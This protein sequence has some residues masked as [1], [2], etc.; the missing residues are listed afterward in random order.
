MPSR[1]QVPGSSSIYTKCTELVLGIQ[2]ASNSAVFSD[3]KSTTMDGAHPQSRRITYL[4]EH[5]VLAGEEH[6]QIQTMS[7]RR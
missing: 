6:H 2:C 7:P 5:R 3:H 4:G 1:L